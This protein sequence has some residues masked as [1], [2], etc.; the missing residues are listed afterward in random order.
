[1][2]F[3]SKSHPFQEIKSSAC[4]SVIVP[5]IALKW[6]LT[7]ISGFQ[8]QIQYTSPGSQSIVHE[9]FTFEQQFNIFVN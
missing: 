1:V 2:V 7:E 8:V 4:S 9:E 6:G 5:A 3:F